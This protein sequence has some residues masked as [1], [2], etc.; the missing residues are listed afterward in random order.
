MVA[1]ISIENHVEMLRSCVVSMITRVGCR[2]C[3]LG[4]W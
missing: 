3:L 1:L 4:D 2:H